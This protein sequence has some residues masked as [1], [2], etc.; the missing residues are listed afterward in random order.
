MCGDPSGQHTRGWAGQRDGP[1]R[2]CLV[3]F[4]T[5][6]HARVSRVASTTHVV[7]Q[8][9]ATAL[10]DSSALTETTSVPQTIRCIAVLRLNF[11]YL[12]IQTLLLQLTTA[13]SHR[14]PK[15]SYVTLPF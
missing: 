9:C 7:Q 1:E 8:S 15:P 12:Q 3:S 5:L 13:L 11:K 14:N 4:G 10:T 6:C 2:G